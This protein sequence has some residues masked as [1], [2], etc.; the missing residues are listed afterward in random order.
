MGIKFGFEGIGGV[1]YVLWGCLEV[2]W[3]MGF[4]IVFWFSSCNSGV[5]LRIDFRKSFIYFFLFEN[6]NYVIFCFYF[7]L[8]LFCLFNVD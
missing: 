5:L 7:F 4:I 2:V 8:V 3:V 1:G 6:L